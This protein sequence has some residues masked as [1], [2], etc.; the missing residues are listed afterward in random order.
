MV[1]HEG[2]E[3]LHISASRDEV[4]D[5][6]GL[7]PG[8]AKRLLGEPN[9]GLSEDL[10]ALAAYVLRGIRVP[11]AAKGDEPAL[12][13]GREVFTQAGCAGCH[14]GPKWT[15]SHLPGP[16]GTLAPS[17][18][19][20]VESVL[21]DVGTHNPA[22]DILGEKGFDIPTLLGLHAT[23]PYLHDGSAETLSQVLENPEHIGSTLE[24]ADRDDLVAFL[25]SLD[26]TTVPVNP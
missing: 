18:E 22:S 25:K 1:P 20:E 2:T 16:V 21:V 14:G 6:F 9:G 15:I 10:D 3:P 17:G 26:S 8:I 11:V 7:A 5:G 24:P 23:A 4:M 19:L 13:R 12:V